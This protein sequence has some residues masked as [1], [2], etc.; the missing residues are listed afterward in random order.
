[1]DC[2]P[3][4]RLRWP[5]A[6]SLLTLDQEGALTPEGLWDYSQNDV[7]NLFSGAFGASV[8]GALRGT[9]RGQP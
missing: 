9:Q 4:G 8:A 1:M 6:A 2:L 7:D 5:D 3:H